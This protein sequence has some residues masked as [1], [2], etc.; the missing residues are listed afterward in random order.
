MRKKLCKQNTIINNDP[1]SP[2]ISAERCM[3]DTAW[4]F[5]FLIIENSANIIIPSTA[6]INTPLYPS[7][8]EK[9]ERDETLWFP[10]GA[11]ESTDAIHGKNNAIKHSII[12]NRVIFPP[13]EI[14]DVV[15][16]ALSSS[17]T[18]YFWIYR[19]I[20]FLLERVISD[21]RNISF[22]CNK[23]FI[24]YIVCILLSY[25]IFAWK[26]HKQK[27][28]LKIHFLMYVYI[29]R[30]FVFHEYVVWKCFLERRNR[31]PIKKHIF[32]RHFIL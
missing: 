2:T 22:T 4:S 32:F 15:K 17:V 11:I 14:W 1:Q 13:K 16:R 21:I 29:L 28:Q 9:L 24:Y 30:V 31:I 7:S 25:N 5:C 8:E 10:T 6:K 20:F 26:K 19:V 23:I 18:R 3:R 27:K 12:P